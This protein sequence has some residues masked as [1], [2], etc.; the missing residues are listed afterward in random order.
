MV[1]AAVNALGGLD[2]LVNIAGRPHSDN[3]ESSVR[4]RSNPMPT[5]KMLPSPP[6][7]HFP[8]SWPCFSKPLPS[9]DEALRP[10]ALITSIRRQALAG[11]SITPPGAVTEPTDHTDR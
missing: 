11:T 3:Q 4:F 5:R 2:I 10:A 1:P 9:S 8:L 6:L 7:V